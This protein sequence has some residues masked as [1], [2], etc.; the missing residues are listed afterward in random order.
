MIGL[1]FV[2]PA[3]VNVLPHGWQNDLVRWLPSSAARTIPD[4]N[5]LQLGYAWARW[6]CRRNLTTDGA[7]IAA[8]R[9][10]AAL[11]KARQALARH[12]SAR[13]CFTAATKKIDEG[14]GHVTTLV[15]E[16]RAALA[17]LSEE[18]NGS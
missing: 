4:D 18:L 1:L 8:G 11:T 9:V 7:T 17:E 13:S 5:A 3:L 14:A 6:V 12:Q 15:E 10:E 2:I 16:V